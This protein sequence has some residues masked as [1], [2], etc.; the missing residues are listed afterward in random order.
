LSYIVLEAGEVV[1]SAQVQLEP[2]YDV[3]VVGGGLGGLSSAAYLARAGRSVLVCEQHARPGGYCTAYPSPSGRFRVE[4]TLQYLMLCGEGEWLDVALRELGVRDQIGFKPLDTFL[5]V[6]GPDYDVMLTFDRDQVEAELVCQFPTE[7]QAIRRLLQEAGTMGRVRPS[8]Q[9]FELM[10]WWEKV[11]AAVQTLPALPVLGKYRHTTVAEGIQMFRDPRL[12]AFIFSLVPCPQ[13]GFLATLF[14]LALYPAWLPRAGG[15]NTLVDA[16][17]A[18]LRKHGGTLACGTQV[19][20]ICVQDGRAAEVELADGRRIGAGVVVSNA[21]A[22]MT[23]KQMVGQEHLPSGF[24]ADLEQRPVAPAIFSVWL[25]VDLDLRALGHTTGR[26]IFNPTHEIDA[27][28]STD[29]EEC[30]LTINMYSLD[31]PSVAPPGYHTVLIE[32]PLPYDYLDRWGIEP[33]GTRGERYQRLKDQVAD[34]L[35]RSAERVLPGLSHHIVEREIATPLTYERYTLN[36]RGSIH[37][38]LQTPAWMLAQASQRTP[39]KGLYQAGHWVN[40]CGMPSV[41]Q[42][43]RNAAALILADH[44]LSLSG[45]GPG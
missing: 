44:S 1:L 39:V 38:W 31:D 23:F 10:S 19:S 21:D 12:R 36:H 9:S 6:I 27:L 5:R 15:A 37:G 40:L 24:L 43:G 20:K 33:D 14:L 34:A 41:I 29:L 42:S 7:A 30:S 2:E 16:F 26:V 17:V 13:A 22:L 8:A 35:I 25:G 11:R 18:A 4:Q 28:T 45:R 3:V 32:A